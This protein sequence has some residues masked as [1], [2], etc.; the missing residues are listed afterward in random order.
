LLGLE[1]ERR[2]VAQMQRRR[3]PGDTAADDD[4]VSFFSH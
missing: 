3:E 4:D 2:E 1:N